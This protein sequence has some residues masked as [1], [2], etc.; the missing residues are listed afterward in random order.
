M[1]KSLNCL[2]IITIQNRKVTRFFNKCPWPKSDREKKTAAAIL[3]TAWK[4]MEKLRE[5][6]YDVRINPGT[7]GLKYFGLLERID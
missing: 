6:G 7:G 4:R 3:N 1:G 2:A 5:A